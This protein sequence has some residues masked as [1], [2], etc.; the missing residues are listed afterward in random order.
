MDNNEYTGSEAD[1]RQNEVNPQQSD[2]QKGGWLPPLDSVNTSSSAPDI[3]SQ[4]QEYTQNK[5]GSAPSFIPPVNQNVGYP[6]PFYPMPP[7]ANPNM[8]APGWQPDN[9]QPYFIYPPQ[10]IS[11]YTAYAVPPQNCPPVYPQRCASNAQPFIPYE[12]G[13]GPYRNTSPSGYRPPVYPDSSPFHQAAYQENEDTV[14]PLSVLCSRFLTEEEY[15]KLYKRLGVF[16]AKTVG[17]LSIFLLLFLAVDFA[18]A[19]KNGNIL[20]VSISLLV[21]VL[22]FL[23]SGVVLLVKQRDFFQSQYELKKAVSSKESVIEIYS[24]RIVELSKN[25]KT[26]MPYSEIKTLIEMPDMIAV[27]DHKE[28]VIVLRAGDL[29]PFD[30]QKIREILYPRLQKA[31]KRFIGPL[32]AGIQEPL[33]IPIIK[34]DEN[35]LLSLPVETEW[36]NWKAY[37][38]APKEGILQLLLLFSFGIALG[39]QTANLFWLTHSFILDILIFTGIYLVLIALIFGIVRYALS[40]SEKHRLDN[41]WQPSGV[42][43]TDYGAA[44][45][46][47]GA[48]NVIPWNRLKAEDKR[49]GMLLQAQINEKTLP[50]FLIS[51]RFIPDKE[52]LMAILREH[53]CL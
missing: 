1:I 48:T 30:V 7:Y 34:N 26:I 25:T 47:A 41:I 31:K 16:S 12:N 28:Q 24:D 39:T 8:A 11:L 46:T 15:R 33:P 13:G 19:A 38:A 32:I 52:K 20:I 9:R 17:I 10:S 23:I 21:S 43:F 36:S 14:H 4:T 45:C 50:Y 2:S 5:N 44:I 35:I 29:I 51:W 22:L 53:G 27:I 40:V 18:F 42:A 49:D 37:A 6:H 3:H